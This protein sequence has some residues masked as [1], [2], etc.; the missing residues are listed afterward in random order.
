M[1]SPVGHTLAGLA[2]FL[3]RFD[4]KSPFR[5]AVVAAVLLANLP[6]LDF[7]FSWMISGDPNLYHQAFTHSLFFIVMIAGA[8]AATWR[9]MSGYFNSFIFYL[10]CLGSHLLLDFFTGP[11]LGATSYGI[12]L[13]SPLTM[14]RFRSPVT[15]LVGP[16]HQDLDQLLSLHNG[17]WALYEAALLMPILI[18]AAMLKRPRS[19]TTENP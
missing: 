8:L 13:L 12:P 11:S 4:G 2:I 16:K 7:L 15:L 10:M 14:E 6:D 5:P 18:L 9:S 3:Q 17:G 1:A 19:L